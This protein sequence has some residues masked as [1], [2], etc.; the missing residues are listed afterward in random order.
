LKSHKEQESVNSYKFTNSRRSVI[1]FTE[2]GL[3]KKLISSLNKINF[4]NLTPIQEECIPLTLKG[5]DILASAETGSGKTGAYII[6]VISFIEKS[7]KNKTIILVPTRELAKQIM[8][9][10]NLFFSKKEKFNSMILIGGESIKDQIFRLKRNPKIIICTPGRAIDHLKRKT[11]DLKDVST[12]IL[13]ETDKMLDMGFGPDIENIIRLTSK[14]RQTLMFSATIPKKIVK[15][16][17][18]YLN[19]PKRITIGKENEIPKNIKQEVKKIKSNEKYDELK[20]ELISRKGSILVFM[21]TKHG[22]DRL[23]KRL[24]NHEIISQAI[25]GDLSQNKRNK[26]IQQFRN[27]KFNILIG[28][29]IVSRGLDIPDIEHVINYDL[30]QVPEDFIHRMGRTARAGKSGK[31]LTFITPENLKLWKEI[32]K[33]INSKSEK[34][35]KSDDNKKF[36]KK[37]SRKDFLKNKKKK[38]VNGFKKSKKIKFSSNKPK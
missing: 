24:K 4:I 8:D 7:K 13:D 26:I 3:S 19:N 21:K 17:E 12:L 11:L 16:A 6:P 23:A 35:S 18:L 30:P 29:D 31:V 28:T 25:H 36:I 9:V 34:K 38:F 20:K 5:N 10:A 1:Y 14:E 2:L 37:K 32:D 15:V 27:N 22:S 33:L